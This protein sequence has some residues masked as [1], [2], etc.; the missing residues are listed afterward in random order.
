MALRTV[1]PKR[2]SARSRVS[3]AGTRC[4]TLRYRA[5]GS[6]TRPE[7]CSST[8]SGTSATVKSVG[9]R[10]PV[11]LVP[12]HRD[13]DRRPFPGARGEG[14]HRVG[15]ADV[16]QVVDEDLPLALRLGHV[17]GEGRGLVAGQPQRHRPR[18][19]LE[20]L[21]A[22][23]RARAARTR[24][25][26][27]PPSSSRSSRGPARAAALARAGPPPPPGR[28]A[29]PRRGRGRR[30]PGPAASSRATREFQGWT[31]RIPA[32]ASAT[33]PGTESTKRCSSDFPGTAK[34]RTWGGVQK[35][36]FFW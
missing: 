1:A 17:R 36:A 25:A 7:P 8:R 23:A 26:P 22:R 16:A 13:R 20:L 15:A 5:H 34:R 6:T 28:R 10:E 18:E 19:L 21:P 30:S 11:E 32:C 4:F 12:V 29:A 27:C 2:H 24:A 35:P 33:R 31:S 9:T 14:A 3:D